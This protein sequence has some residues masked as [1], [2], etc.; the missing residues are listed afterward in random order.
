M[1]KNLRLWANLMLGMS[2]AILIAVAGL[3]YSGLAGLEAVVRDAE[4]TQLRQSMA[5]L[6]AEVAGQARLAEALS[7][8]VANLPEVRQRFAAGDRTWLLGALLPPYQVLAKDYGAAQFQFHTPPATS[9]LR[10]H[11]PEKYGDDLS[12]IRHSVVDTS[13]TGAPHGGLEVGVAGLGVRGM[14]PVTT[15]AGDA[16]PRV[17]AGA[18]ESGAVLGV[19]EFGMSFGRPF[20]DAFKARF[21]V[22]AGLWLAREGAFQ[23]FSG[24][25]GERPFLAPERLQAALAGVPQFAQVQ[26]DGRPFAVYATVI[27]DY[28]GA[29]LGVVEVARDS[30]P[31]RA[32]I[33]D[34]NTR[35]WAIGVLVLALGLALALL[36]ANPLSRRIG[37]LNEGMKRMAAGDL[38]RDVAAAGRDELADLARTANAMRLHL[39]ELVAEVE[40]KAAAVHRAAGA[41]AEAVE[42]QAAN[43]TQMSASVAEITSTMEELSASSSQIAEYSETVVEVARRA[44]ESSRAGAEAMQ[45]LGVRMA[46]IRADNQGAL[47]EILAL[48]RSSKEV[49][50]VMEIIDTVAD[51]TRLIAFN[52]ALEAASAGESG[53]RFG[54]VAS[55]IRRLA[56]S[57]SE[58][59]G[60]IAQKVAETQESIARLVVTSEQGTA[61]IAHGLQESADTQALLDALVGGAGET[62]RAAQQISLSSQQQ[63]TASN[64]VVVALREIVAAS[65]DTAAAVRRI[66]EIA[67]DMTRLS[68]TLAALVATFT[69]ADDGGR[70]PAAA[71]E[72]G[73]PAVGAGRVPTRG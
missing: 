43:S 19:V 73:A 29:P 22:D 64:Q 23:G 28:S 47:Q 11:M 45:R 46:E 62:T 10:L 51:Q 13:R 35:T 52:A 72:P 67:E 31:Y 59:T 58:S 14:V 15:P 44:F 61:A 65:S 39:H 8:L 50:R 20:F 56:D 60:E 69:R 9:F 17:A 4:R 66:S 7:A 27:R 34:A 5:A 48:G 12:A 53:R 21:G 26:H 33:D 41:I 1:F 6:T 63:R 37:M 55:E 38:G 49:S 40:A 57:V 3:S 24:T 70:A 25:Y 68:G 2:A 54:V 18:T 16:R 30:S 71:P 36:T 42:G 32:M